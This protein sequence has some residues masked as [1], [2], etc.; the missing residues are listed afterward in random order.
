MTKPS[1]SPS[2]SS[3]VSVS[4]NDTDEAEDAEFEEGSKSARPKVEK[5]SED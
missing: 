4:G 1:N 2:S 3:S 5:A